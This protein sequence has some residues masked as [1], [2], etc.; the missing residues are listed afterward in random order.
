[1]HEEANLGGSTTASNTLF[2]ATATAPGGLYVLGTNSGGHDRNIVAV[3]PEGT[4]NFA[5]EIT[6]QVKA[7]VGYT[8]IYASNVQRPGNLIDRSIDR[9]QLPS[10]QTFSPSIPG[11]VHPAFTWNGTD[12]W[13]QGW[14]VGLSLRF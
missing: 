9:T 6:S 2:G 8:I 3:V 1:M 4:L 5:V 14:N 13:A 7:F 12:F 11:A 10:S